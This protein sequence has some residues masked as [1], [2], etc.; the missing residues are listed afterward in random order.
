MGVHQELSRALKD[1]KAELAEKEN[2]L[3]AKQ[4]QQVS[5]T[6]PNKNS[7]SP[8]QRSEKRH[9]AY[10]RSWAEQLEHERC[11]T[12]ARRGAFKATPSP[13]TTKGRSPAQKQPP[14]ADST[15]PRS[16]LLAS[17]RRAAA[18]ASFD[19][20]QARLSPNPQP[21]PWPEHSTVWSASRSGARRSSTTSGGLPRSGKH[22]RRSKGSKRSASD[23][24]SKPGRT[25]SR[26]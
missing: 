14:A 19:R 10:Q 22:E 26:T 11:A 21:Q 25:R 9:D 5:S 7:L 2:R 15:L 18:R 8:F 13:T 12:E 17:T 24:L 4:Q 23:T 6:A 16:P 20:L 3:A 1:L